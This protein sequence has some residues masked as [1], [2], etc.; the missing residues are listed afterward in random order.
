MLDRNSQDQDQASDWPSGWELTAFLYSSLTRS[1]AYGPPT[2]SNHSF[3]PFTPHSQ[4]KIFQRTSESSITDADGIPHQDIKVWDI[5][6]G[7][8]GVES[9]VR[10]ELMCMCHSLESALRRESFFPSFLPSPQV[11]TSGLSYALSIVMMPLSIPSLLLYRTALTVIYW[12]MSCTAS[13]AVTVR[14]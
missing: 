7:V 2:R 14:I 3:A 6:E 11:Y 1:L 12:M 10:D 8:V 13:T 9:G 4:D 5:K